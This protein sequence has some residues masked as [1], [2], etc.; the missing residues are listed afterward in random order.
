MSDKTSLDSRAWKAFFVRNGRLRSGWRALIYIPVLGLVYLLLNLP[1]M[2]FNIQLRY[3]Y[4][5]LLQVLVVLVGTW[6][7]RRFVDKRDFASFGFKLDRRG[8]LD[9]GLGLLLGLALMGGIFLVE[10][11][12]GWIT[13]RGFAWQWQP[14]D[15]FLRNFFWAVLVQ[16]VCVAIL[17]ETVCRGYL[18]P[19]LEEGLGLPWAVVITSSL[20]GLMHLFNPSAGGWADYVI[21]FTLTL[22]G[23]LLAMAY[24]VRR[25]LWLPMALHFAWNL[26]EYNIFALTG[27][28]PDYA[29]F[30][31]TD[32]TG[33]AVWVGLPHSAFGPEV[34]LLGILAMLAGI[35]VLWRLR[36]RSAARG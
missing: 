5:Q 25:T 35:A 26:L 19:T 3:S 22:A 12:F 28:E 9:V 31:V 24:L 8:L 29:R 6:V 20:F 32:V 34:G 36:R 18:L 33:P 1:L 16:N 11:A 27:A 23:V 10:L 2:L 14:F 13:V 30:L 15:S 7:C 4:E 21:P 17:E